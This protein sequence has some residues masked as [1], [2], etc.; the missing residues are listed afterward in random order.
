MHHHAFAI[1]AE[2]DEGIGAA[3]AW[4]RRELGMEAKG[5]PDVIVLSYGLLS[6]EDARRVAALAAQAPLAGAHKALVVAASRAYHEAQNA[7]LKLFEEPPAGT[8]LFLVLPTLGGLLPTLRSRIQILPRARQRLARTIPKAAEEF[9]KAGREKRVS[10]AK[11]L[12]SGRDDEERREN[13]D[14]A[15]AIVNGVEAMAYHDGFTKSINME[16]LCE[17]QKLR[18]C[19]HDRAAPVRII[20]EHLALVAPSALA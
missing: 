11:R 3:Q 5:N 2:A 10:I 20:L 16:L 4:V 18:D 6:V 7:L 13:R 12:A 17:I 14:E 15:L 9:L 19:L 8:Y 1:E